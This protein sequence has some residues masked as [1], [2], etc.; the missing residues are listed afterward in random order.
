MVATIF[1]IFM[2]INRPDFVQK[3]YIESF[4]IES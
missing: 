3:Q 1:K 2:R 4:D